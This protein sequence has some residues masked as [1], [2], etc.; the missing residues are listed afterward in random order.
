M[1]GRL[2]DRKS[3][4]PC[5]TFSS[6]PSRAKGEN[7]REVEQS[8]KGDLAKSKNVRSSDHYLFVFFFNAEDATVV[9]TSRKCFSLFKFTRLFFSFDPKY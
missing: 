4:T 1:L 8:G 7:N 5:S 3:F 2:S 9:E 6:S